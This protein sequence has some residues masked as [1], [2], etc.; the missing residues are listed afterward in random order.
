MDSW[1]AAH[2]IL[3]IVTISVL[4]QQG[5]NHCMQLSPRVGDAT[6]LTPNC[7]ASTQLELDKL[8]QQ[9]QALGLV[10]WEGWSCLCHV[11]RD[12]KNHNNGDN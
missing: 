12:N 7:L 2:V 4:L 9:C 8:F 10:V 6:N 5:F 3:T 1:V 11:S